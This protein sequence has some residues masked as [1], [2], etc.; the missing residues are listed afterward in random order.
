MLMT[1]LQRIRAIQWAVEHSQLRFDYFLRID[2]DVYVDV[3]RLV[4]LYQEDMPS[5]K[6]YSGAV[7]NGGVVHRQGKWC[8]I[9]YYL[10]VPL[11]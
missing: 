9:Y 7:W 1:F 3:N 8:C 2:D 10:V 6:L 5:F 11:L 4:R